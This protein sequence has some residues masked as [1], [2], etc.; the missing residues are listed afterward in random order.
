MLHFVNREHALS[1][2]RGRRAHHERMRRGA[3]ERRRRL[4]SLISS[5]RFEPKAS[6][7]LAEALGCGRTTLWEDLQT[8]DLSGRC[9]HCGQLLPEVVPAALEAG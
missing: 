5:G 1:F 4:V 9:L 8:L 7:A 2:F 6:R 3:V